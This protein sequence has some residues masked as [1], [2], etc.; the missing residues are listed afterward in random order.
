[1][2]NPPDKEQGFPPRRNE[3]CPDGSTLGSRAAPEQPKGDD[4]NASAFTHQN[5]QAVMKPRITGRR[6]PTQ[7]QTLGAI[8]GLVGGAGVAMFGAAFTAVSWFMTNG[9]ARQWLSTTGTALLFLTIPLL[10][11]GG[12]CLDWMERDKPQHYSKVAHYEDNDEE[13]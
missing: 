1:M 8:V 2:I 4:M 7:A 13:Q 10:M 3:G 9:S 12:Y 11:F 6:A 5:A